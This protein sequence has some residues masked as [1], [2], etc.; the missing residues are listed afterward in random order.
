MG[1]V[2][3]GLGLDLKVLLTFRAFSFSSKP[4]I[5]SPF[6]GELTPVCVTSNS[7]EGQTTEEGRRMKKGSKL[8]R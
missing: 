5:R 1:R 2:M 8:P 3:R 6:L 4:F 7:L